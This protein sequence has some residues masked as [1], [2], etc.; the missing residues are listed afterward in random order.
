[1][2]S[3]SSSELTAHTHRLKQAEII[4]TGKYERT[5]RDA[6]PAAPDERVADLPPVIDDFA[7]S[8]GL[9]ATWTFW[10]RALL[11]NT[12]DPEKLQDEPSI[13]LHD[14][15]AA[16]AGGHHH[17]HHAHNLTYVVAL[18]DPDAPSRDKPKWAEFCHW[19]ASG[20]LRPPAR[21]DPKAPEGPCAPVLADLH[22]LVAYKPPGPPEGT[23]KHRYVFLAF[24]PANGTTDRLHL[25]KPA[26]RKHWGYGQGGG[27]GLM[28][29]GR[30]TKG[31]R[32]WAAENGLAPVGELASGF[33]FC[34]VSFSP[35]P[36]FPRGRACLLV[37]CLPGMRVANGRVLL[38]ANFIYAE[39]REQ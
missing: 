24:V 14:L 22:E 3:K 30:R 1:M 39:N 2:H 27:G 8:L 33:L 10:E 12:L 21:C 13:A 28:G 38:G 7:P 16:A 11:G 36:K 17:H 31:V 18:T 32:E 5:S 9:H 37:L 35:S 29:K 19:V 6:R 20:V 4:P 23:G 25:S 26:G 34:V 15:L